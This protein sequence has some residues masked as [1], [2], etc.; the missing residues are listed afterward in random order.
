MTI[1]EEYSKKL[2]SMLELRGSPVAIIY[3]DVAAEDAVDGKHPACYAL[4]DASKGKV[5]DLNSETSQCPGGTW[6]LGLGPRPSG[7]AWKGLKEF[8]VNGEKLCASQGA[9]WRMLVNCTDP[10]TGL[11]EHVIYRPLES[12]TTD[13]ELVLFIA[14]PKQACRLAQ[15]LQ[16]DDG[17]PLRPELGGSTCHQVISYPL[18]TGEPTVALGDWTNR[19]PDNFKYDEMFV[20]VP[21][22]RMHNMMAAIPRCTAGVAKME[23]PPGFETFDE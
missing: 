20:T 15:L 11:A 19:S 17:N 1:Y 9:F 23:R 22:H 8:L 4:I 13:P 12:C 2:K 5:I 14:T 3:T 7:E 16:F 21:W 18:V 10:P 6:H